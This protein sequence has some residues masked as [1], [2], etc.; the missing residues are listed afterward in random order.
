MRI[1]DEI[2]QNR[3]L[4]ACYL[5]F[6]QLERRYSSH[7]VAAVRRDI[8]KLGS[9]P[10]QI[11]AA[12][13]K[14]QLSALHAKGLKATSLARLASSWRGFYRFAVS[15]GYLT[16]NPADALKVPKRPKR[17]PKALSI[18]QVISLL[19]REEMPASLPLARGYLLVALIYGTGLRIHEAIGLDW[20]ESATKDAIGCLSLSAQEVQVSGKGGKTRL[21][22]LPSFVADLLVRWQK[23]LADAYKDYPS[24]LFVS[25]NGGRLSIR[26]AQRDISSYAKVSGLEVL[27]HPHMLRHSFGSHMLQESQNLRAVQDLLGHESISSTQIYTSLDFKHLSGVYDQAFPRAKSTKA[28][29]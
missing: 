22:P 3:K 14:L 5:N 18:D 1:I 15:K 8:A 21:I 23:F 29:D 20:Q 2:V 27:L 10:L 26:Q 24:H 9:S 4:V 16:A 12:G 11:D 17:L 13:L 28:K 19:Q 25:K 6:L 7:T